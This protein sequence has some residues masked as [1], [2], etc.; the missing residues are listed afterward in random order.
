MQRKYTIQTK[1]SRNIFLK[2]E[3]NQPV[4]Q[5]DFYYSINKNKQTGTLNEHLKSNQFTTYSTILF[6]ALINEPKKEINQ[7]D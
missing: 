1:S 4:T 2:E 7:F 5:Q 6:K 3:R